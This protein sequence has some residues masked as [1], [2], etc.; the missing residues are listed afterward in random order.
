M[1][2]HQNSIVFLFFVLLIIVTRTQGKCSSGCN[3]AL[4]SYYITEG[5]NLTYIS[6]LFNQ[7]T[8]EILKYNPNLKNPD[9]IQSQTR[10]NVPFTCECLNGVFLGHTFSYTTQPGSTYK[11]IA[12][13]DYANLTTEEWVNR[14]NY[15][16]SLDIPDNANI[17]VTVNCS[18]GD[19]HVSKDYGLFLT[20]PLRPSDNLMR[21]AVDSGVP[22]EVLQ[23]YNPASDFSAG[24]GLVFVPAKG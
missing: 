8:S 23:K 12:K 18:C 17:N 3:L 10:I 21:V 1:T 7:P 20:Y 9:V 6:N 13:L 24:N 16:P 22:A 4:A 14:V 2:T 5:T 15:Y 11:S 19:R